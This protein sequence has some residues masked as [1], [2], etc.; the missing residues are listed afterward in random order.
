MTPRLLKCT[1]LS[2]EL[3]PFYNTHSFKIS[4]NK[5]SCNTF[6]IHSKCITM[7]QFPT[8]DFVLPWSSLEAQDEDDD[9]EPYEYPTQGSNDPQHD[10]QGDVSIIFS[11][12]IYNA[13]LMY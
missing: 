6:V 5:E 2:D 10:L 12:C 11:K 8:I 9:E 1:S 3:L 4:P 7:S 13:F